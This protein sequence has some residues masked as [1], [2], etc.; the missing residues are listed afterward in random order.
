MIQTIKQQENGFLINGNMSIPNNPEN[1]HYQ[2]V[3]DAINGTGDYE[4]N[5][6]TIEPEFT[7]AELQT[8]QEA[9]F[10]ADRFILLDKA[11]K[12]IN[13]LEDNNQ[14][15]TTWRAYR[16]ALRDATISWILPEI[17]Q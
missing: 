8:K 11:D 6:I 4:D 7:E 9:E 10:R 2:E 12:A 5:P 1:R 13:T 3:Q 16:Q 17:P 14:D 15:A